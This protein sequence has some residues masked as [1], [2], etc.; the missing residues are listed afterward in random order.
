MKFSQD[1]QEYLIGVELIPSYRCH[2]I[3]NIHTFLKPKQKMKELGLYL[4]IIRFKLDRQ[5]GKKNLN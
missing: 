2:L 4:K 3:T 1:Y 5:M